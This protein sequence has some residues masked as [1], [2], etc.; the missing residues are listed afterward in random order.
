MYQKYRLTIPRYIYNILHILT[1][2]LRLRLVMVLRVCIR[3]A[4][5]RRPRF[6]LLDLCPLDGDDACGVQI[7][8]HDEYL[9]TPGS[10]F[11]VVLVR[12]LTLFLTCKDVILAGVLHVH[13]VS[14]LPLFSKISTSAPTNPPMLLLLLFDSQQS[15]TASARRV[16]TKNAV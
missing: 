6:L 2:E 7:S 5:V 12:R 15:A 8:S 13:V 4:L 14:L 10:L 16:N 1:I 9:P 11:R 3:L